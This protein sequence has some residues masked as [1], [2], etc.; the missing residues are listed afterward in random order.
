MSKRQFSQKWITAIVT[1][2]VICSTQV[3]NAAK[4]ADKYLSLTNPYW[5]AGRIEYNQAGFDTAGYSDKFWWGLSPRHPYSEHEMLS[6]E[7]GAA[8]YYDGIATA[9]EAMWLTDKFFFPDWTTNSQFIIESD[10]VAWDDDPSPPGNPV[11]G[12]DTGHSSIS[13]GDVTVAID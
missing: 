12:N 8:I 6:G 3:S 5:R 9:P 4:P 10:P 2:G 1:V 7:W 11:T 13:N